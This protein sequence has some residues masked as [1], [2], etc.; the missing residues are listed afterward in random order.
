[1]F[2]YFHIFLS[3]KYLEKYFDKYP[4]EKKNKKEAIVAPIPKKYFSIIK[5]F[6]EKF[7]KKIQYLNKR[8]DLK[9]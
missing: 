2:I 3:F 9:R 4:I 1:M 7:P 5:R 8:V 6:L